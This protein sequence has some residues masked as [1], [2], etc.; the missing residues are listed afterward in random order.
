MLQTAKITITQTHPHKLI[1]RNVSK[2]AT[3]V[4]STAVAA[5]LLT[6]GCR[7]LLMLLLRAAMSS[8]ADPLPSAQ[9]FK[10]LLSASAGH[11]AAVAWGD[12]QQ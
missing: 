9:L 1:C 7:L 8:E 11:A 2:H 4:S 10:S 5:V 12:E 3:P 6:A